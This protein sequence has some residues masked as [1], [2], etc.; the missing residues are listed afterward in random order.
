MA[1][2]LFP[3]VGTEGDLAAQASHFAFEDQDAPFAAV[4]LQ[5]LPCI[6]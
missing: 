3:V 4:E 6:T 5:R 1:G 2:H